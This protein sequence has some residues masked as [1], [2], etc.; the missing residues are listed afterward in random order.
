M[1]LPIHLHAVHP[2][3][4]LRGA[5]RLITVLDNDALS[6][7]AVHFA[8]NATGCVP[9]GLFSQG[10]VAAAA[11]GLSAHDLRFASAEIACDEE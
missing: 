11:I 10:D 5:S 7:L 8:L 9:A 3:V 1:L 2:E 4:T 6:A